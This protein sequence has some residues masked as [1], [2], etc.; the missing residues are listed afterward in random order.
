MA[1]NFRLLVGLGNPTSK[2]EKTRHNAGFWFLDEIASRNRL[3]FSSDARSQGMI[4]KWSWQNEPIFLLKPM[5]Y[6]NRSGG[7]VAALAHFYKIAPEQ[8]LVAHD[9]L[10]FAPGTVKLKL[11]G[12]HG[13]HN[14]LRDIVSRLGTP[15]FCR[16]R[17][18]IG[19]PGDRDKV[20]DYVLDRPS[21]ADEALLMGAVS[22]AV[23]HLPSIL[24]E[25]MQDAMNKL[26]SSV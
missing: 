2:Y 8:I 9:E 24:G 15:N 14:G 1:A 6:M 20:A 4:C 5:Q 12:G 21:R 11:G 19:H 23:D 25:A 10:D 22:R 3:A 16:L 26:H 17:L 7:P 13:G 18:G